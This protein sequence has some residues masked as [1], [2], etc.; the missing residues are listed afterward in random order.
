MFQISHA[1]MCD[2]R[3]NPWCV[4]V[5]S[6]QR[7]SF[8]SPRVN[9]GNAQDGNYGTPLHVARQ[10]DRYFYVGE[11]YVTNPTLTSSRFR[12]R[13]LV[14]RYISYIARRVLLHVP[15]F[16][17]SFHILWS[18]REANVTRSLKTYTKPSRTHSRVRVKPH[19]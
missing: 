9:R 14:Q 18:V 19:L 17:T 13:S 12:S 6:F 16:P 7:K 3:N 11:K 15:H 4:H 1:D 8:V 5:G 10:V 2:E